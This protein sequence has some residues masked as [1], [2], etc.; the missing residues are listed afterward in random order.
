[1]VETGLHLGDRVALELGEAA[2]PLLLRE[3]A[4]LPRLH[5]IGE[6]E[7]HDVLRLHADI[8]AELLHALR[9]E[10][11]GVIGSGVLTEPYQAQLAAELSRAA[12]T[13]STL[14]YTCHTRKDSRH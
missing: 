3:E 12:S 10:G 8:L 13:Q 7:H 6:H 5:T 2:H 1:M 9:A 4:H 14:N 11:L